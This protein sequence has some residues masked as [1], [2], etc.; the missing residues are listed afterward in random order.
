MN[1]EPI[2]QC[3]AALEATGFMRSHD[4]STPQGC[5][6]C[7]AH[8][9]TDGMDLTE[10]PNARSERNERR[11]VRYDD[12]MTAD[13]EWREAGYFRFGGEYVSA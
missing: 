8:Y 2:T 6:Y 5:R 3:P 10:N 11:S 13:K 12:D 1:N 7:G 9:I 4:F